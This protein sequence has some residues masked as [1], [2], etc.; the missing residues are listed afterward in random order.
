MFFV[1][2]LVS[3]GASAQLTAGP[4][5]LVT[6]QCAFSEGPLWLAE[7]KWI[8][9]DVPKNGI[10]FEDGSAYRRP[11]N[12]ANGLTLDRQGRLIACESTKHRIS[13]TE[14]DGTITVL[15]DSYNGKPLNSTNDVV[16]GV[17]G[18][19][20]FTDP[21]G[22][23]KDDGTGLGFSGVY[24]IR[25]DGSGLALIADDMKY[26]NGI[27]LSPDGKTLYVG[28]YLGGHIRA[29][30]LSLDGKASNPRV[31]CEV[32]SPDGFKVD[33]AG[34]VWSS[35]SKGIQVFGLDGKFIESVDFSGTPT[36][37]AFGGPDGRTLFITARKLVYKV[38]VRE[39]G[40]VPAA[41]V[42]K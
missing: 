38:L 27:A 6:D 31:F 5:E 40:I 32:K 26:P 11:S 15:A 30:D 34:R 23:R 17:D 22:P 18:T 13:R 25:P 8:F 4:V 28:D 16:V 3:A 1:V 35:S 41:Q 14:A 42:Q 39:A 2:L 33:R 37:C 9:S 36:N 24:G 20:Y 21:T 12:G 19:V 7:G 29:Y 10:F